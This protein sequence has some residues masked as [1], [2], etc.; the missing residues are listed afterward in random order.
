MTQ[1]NNANSVMHNIP[2]LKGQIARGKSDPNE[3]FGII[4]CSR[5]AVAIGYRCVYLQC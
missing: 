4:S 1:L 2:T 3:K 5:K